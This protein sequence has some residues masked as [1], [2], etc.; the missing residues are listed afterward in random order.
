MAKDNFHLEIISPEGIQFTGDV[1]SVT[2]PSQLGEITI[3][4]NHASLS[5]KLVEGEIKIISGGKTTHV[6]I[7]GGFFEISDNQ[8]QVLSD[9]AIKA[10]SVELAKAEVRKKDAETKLS[11][12][13][14]I[15]DTKIIERDLQRSIL[16]L[17]FGQNIKK[18]QKSQ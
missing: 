8:G 5:T 11:E 12:K 14:D 17:K 18:R 10:E 7:N 1:E 9:F 16:E 2:L 13:K 15:F 6:A 3:L 4:P